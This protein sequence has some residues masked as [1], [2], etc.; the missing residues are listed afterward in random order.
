M[1][2]WVSSFGISVYKK[3]NIVSYTG[4]WHKKKGVEAVV[5]EH[6]WCHNVCYLVCL[7]T[8]YNVSMFFIQS[9]ISDFEFACKMY[10]LLFVY[11][12]NTLLRYIDIEYP[13]QSVSVCNLL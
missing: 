4:T 10:A 1:N 11:K 7:S 9:V 13:F 12:E 6:S 5:N 8:E 3:S 2:D